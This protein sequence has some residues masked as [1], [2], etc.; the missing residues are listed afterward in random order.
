MTGQPSRLCPFFG[1][2]DRIPLL[3]AI[4]LVLTFWL[5][6]GVGGAADRSYTIDTDPVRLGIKAME[7]GN[8]VEAKARFEEAVA[9]NHEVHRA[10]FGLAEIAIRE[11]RY[12]DAEAFYRKSIAAGGGNFPMANAGLGLLLLR[13]GR[14]QE[15]AQ[16]FDL[17]LDADS[18]LWRAHYGKARLHLA[19]EQWNKAKK[20]LDH[21]A[22][23]RGLAKGEEKYQYG[24]ALY[25]LG[26]GDVAGAEK[27]ALLAMHLDPTDPDYG[28]LVARI[29]EMD[30]NTILAINAYE[31]ALAMPG[32]TPTAP[33]LR[34]LGTLYRKEKRFNEARDSLTR[35]VGV[36]STYAP[37]LKDLGDIYRLANQHDKAARAYLRYIML[38]R[39]DLEVLLDLAGSCYEIRRFAQG[40]EAAKTARKLE[41]DNQAAQFQFARSGIYN[42]DAAIKAEAAALMAELPR[43]LPWQAND[44]VALSSWQTSRKDYA[45]ALKS[46][47]RAGALDPQQSNIPFQR[48]IINL[49]MSQPDQAVADFRQAVDLNP[50]SPAN[51]LNLGIA[52]YQGGNLQEAEPAFR[53]AVELDPDKTMA[54]LLLAQV[55]A[56]TGDLAEAE[57]EYRQVLD[58]EPVNAKAMRGLGFCRIRRADY[59]AAVTSYGDA[60]RIEPDNADGWSGLGSAYLGLNNLEASEAAFKKARA[61]DPDNI[62]L[63][64]G[65]ELLNQA[66]A[67]GKENQ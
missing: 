25:L 21:G 41:P 24:M 48:G 63:V 10:M 32:M 38:E 28:T 61:I 62:M 44:L 52:Y 6:P 35:A 3:G 49:R 58:R 31:Q 4:L 65:T 27:S 26:T 16:E 8:V 20:E 13:L 66:K 55:Q 12:P 9:N 5:L 7:K 57:K 11:G 17:A 34:N 23:L 30:D 64:K 29:Y 60:T 1:N 46:L 42:Q 39:D 43:D 33:M 19:A 2:H 37:A 51:H 47:E 54:R 22:D 59:G 14:D 56:A 15:A 18:S 67:A 53:K 40:A 45:A 36:D 50:D